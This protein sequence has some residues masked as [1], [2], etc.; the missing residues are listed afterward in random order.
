MNKKAINYF[1]TLKDKMIEIMNDMELATNPGIV[2]SLISVYPR[3]YFNIRKSLKK[4]PEVGM[5]KKD[6]E[7]LAGKGVN[8]GLIV[9]QWLVANRVN[10]VLKGMWGWVEDKYFSLGRGMSGNSRHSLVLMCSYG[11]SSPIRELNLGRYLGNDVLKGDP[12]DLMDDNS[13][14]RRT[15]RE[16]RSREG[17]GSLVINGSYKLVHSGVQLPDVDL[18]DS[19]YADGEERGSKTEAMI[20][21][22]RRHP[23]YSDHPVWFYKLNGEKSVIQDGIECKLYENN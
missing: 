21:F 14:V 4:E 11:D 15:L 23:A 19:E 12:V 10:S 16:I 20:E 6:L 2:A 13:K 5:E 8:E 17:I 1:K 18:R 3:A 22:S 9:D 7:I